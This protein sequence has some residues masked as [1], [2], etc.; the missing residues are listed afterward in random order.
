MSQK[1]VEI[2]QQGERNRGSLREDLVEAMKDRPTKGYD[3]QVKA[4]Y[5]SLVR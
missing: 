2:P 5:E 4:Y 3:E 1:K